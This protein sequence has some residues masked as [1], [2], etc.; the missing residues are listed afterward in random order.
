MWLES[1]LNIT[2]HEKKINSKK[3]FT[4]LLMFLNKILNTKNQCVK[5]I[6]WV[7]LVNCLDN[8]SKQWKWLIICKSNENQIQFHRTNENFAFDLFLHFEFS[9]H[10][11]FS[12]FLE[13]GISIQ[14]AKNNQKHN[15]RAS[16]KQI[17]SNL[18]FL[19]E[20]FVCR[21]DKVL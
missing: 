12:N 21:H 18:H 2:K 10:I 9:L 15:S 20:I 1:L 13:N 8:K 6:L 17:K 16:K 19:Q 5:L 14:N 11:S 3:R 7:I 4:A